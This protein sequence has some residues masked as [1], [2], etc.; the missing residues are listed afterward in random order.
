MSLTALA[1]ALTANRRPASKLVLI[2]LA[3]A[4]NEHHVSVPHLPMLARQVGVE[5]MV[6]RCLLNEL[7][8]D[9]IIESVADHPVDFL[10]H[11]EGFLL[12][13]DRVPVLEHAE[14]PWSA[15]LKV[16]S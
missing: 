8:A 13:L 7:V 2:H 6:L 4:A 12:H 9:K 1:V 15:D 5:E 11:T 14:S 3:D 16:A 10:A